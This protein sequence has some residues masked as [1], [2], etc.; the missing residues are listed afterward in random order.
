[1]IVLQVFGKPTQA[2]FDKAVTEARNFFVKNP[3]LQNVTA[4][5]NRNFVVVTDEAY[6][7]DG[8]RNDD[9]VAY[10]AKAFH[11]DKFQQ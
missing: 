4:V 1:V 9:T 11:P 5:K 8:T 2:A 7:L 10:L 6:Y 3:A